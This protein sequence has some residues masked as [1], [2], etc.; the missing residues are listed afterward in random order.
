MAVNQTY[1]SIDIVTFIILHSAASSLA[2]INRAKNQLKGVE[3]QDEA[4]QAAL[5]E[6]AEEIRQA[7]GE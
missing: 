5:V 1:I 6:G 3:T 2:K 7:V 4:L